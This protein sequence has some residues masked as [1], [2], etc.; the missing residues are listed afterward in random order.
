MHSGTILL[1]LLSQPFFENCENNVPEDAFSKKTFPQEENF[2]W[3]E[4]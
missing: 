3:G 4:N 2:P 1:S